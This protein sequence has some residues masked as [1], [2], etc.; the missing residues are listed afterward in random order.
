M[1]QTHGAAPALATGAAS[2]G[3]SDE[4]LDAALDAASHAAADAGSDAAL[5]AASA[6]FASL[7][8]R[9]D[10]HH[11]KPQASRPLGP[12]T[13]RKLGVARAVA[14]SAE[15]DAKPDAAQGAALRAGARG[16]HAA[17][18]AKHA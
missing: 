14:S 3:A 2:D 5:D 17:A 11:C 18:D 10:A 6:P 8:S 1:V 16:L 7:A 15:R 9:D 4:A 13:D 12:H